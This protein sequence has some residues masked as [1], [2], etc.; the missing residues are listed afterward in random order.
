[1]DATL[2]S[3]S[4]MERSELGVCVKSFGLSFAVTSLISALLVVLKE[5][6]EDTVLALMKSATGH[7][8][9]THGIVNIVLFLFLGW[10]FT[11]PND[12]RGV[13]ITSGSLVALI[14]ASTIISGLMITGFFAL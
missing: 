12:G 10:L 8:W 7:H 5:T 1:M 9:I 3:K 4:D 14:V 2:K 13:N 6:N 11:R